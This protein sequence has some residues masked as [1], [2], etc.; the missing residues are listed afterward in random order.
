MRLASLHM[1]K[2]LSNNVFLC[3][4]VAVLRVCVCGYTAIRRRALELSMVAVNVSPKM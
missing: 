1:C 4:C 2:K 3:M